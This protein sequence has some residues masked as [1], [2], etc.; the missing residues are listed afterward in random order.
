MPSAAVLARRAIRQSA[1]RHQPSDS[2]YPTNHSESSL[3]ALGYNMHKRHNYLTIEG[4]NLTGEDFHLLDRYNHNLT[5]LCGQNLNTFQIAPQGV[6]FC[7][8]CYNVLL[9]RTRL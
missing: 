7:R 3:S 5:T 9:V 4:D 6:A 1:K 2:P 8:D